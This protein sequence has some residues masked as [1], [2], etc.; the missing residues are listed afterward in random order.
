MEHSRQLLRKKVEQFNQASR[1]RGDDTRA[2]FDTVEHY[3]FHQKRSKDFFGFA[4]LFVSFPPHNY[5]IQVTTVGNMQARR[6]K[7]CS[8]RAHNAR[9]FLSVS[10]NRVQVWGWKKYKRKVNNRHWQ[11]RVIDGEIEDLMR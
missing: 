11:L 2:H 7:I 1:D 8:E 3:N 6:R 10:C 5:A 4:D 9:A